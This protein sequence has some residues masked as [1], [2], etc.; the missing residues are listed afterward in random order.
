M[1]L[2]SPLASASSA[3]IALADS[4]RSTP[5]SAARGLTGSL[6]QSFTGLS[7]K[8]TS[9]TKS[10]WTVATVTSAVVK[11][12]NAVLGEPPPFE[13]ADEDDDFAREQQNVLSRKDQ[14]KV[15]KAER[16]K[17]D[18]HTEN[19]IRELTLQ[20][21]GLP[22]KCTRVHTHARVRTSAHIRT[23]AASWSTNQR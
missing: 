11:W 19:I 13:E 8:S 1:M 4:E 15:I 18:P 17:K 3:N 20:Q 10:K 9:S 5:T 16:R 2:T 6:R 7:L 23:H 21:V 14:K 22:I 12:R